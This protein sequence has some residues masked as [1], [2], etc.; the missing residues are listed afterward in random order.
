MRSVTYT[1]I[2]AVHSIAWIPVGAWRSLAARSVRDAEVGGSNPLAPTKL[3]P[4]RAAS[5]SPAATSSRRWERRFS[6]AHAD[7]YTLLVITGV[8]L[9]ARTHRAHAWCDGEIDVERF[10]LRALRWQGQVDGSDSATRDA[11]E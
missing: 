3:T 2:L 9:V 5:G 11:H 1:A 4:S 10:G 6:A 7:Q 8:D